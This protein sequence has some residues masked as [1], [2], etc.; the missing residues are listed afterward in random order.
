M[1][2]YPDRTSFLEAGYSPEPEN[3]VLP[4]LQVNDELCGL[5]RTFRLVSDLFTV[6][7]RPLDLMSDV[8]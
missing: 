8:L 2:G 3:R 5:W 4:G 6:N 7:T 1:I